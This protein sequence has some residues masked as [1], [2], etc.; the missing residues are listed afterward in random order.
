MSAKLF[1]VCTIIALYVSVRGEDTQS[2]E[3]RYLRMYIYIY[4][5][6]ILQW[7]VC[8]FYPARVVGD[9]MWKMEWVR[10]VKEPV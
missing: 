9:Q 2:I 5:Y 1:R 3:Q 10:F 4:R 8:Q 7:N 6:Y